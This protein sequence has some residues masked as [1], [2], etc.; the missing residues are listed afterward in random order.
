MWSMDVLDAAFTVI[1][2][3][4][5]VLARMARWLYLAKLWIYRKFSMA[6][7]AKVSSS[8]FD[9]SSS[10]GCIA[11]IVVAH[12]CGFLAVMIK[13]VVDSVQVDGHRVKAIWGRA[14]STS[15]L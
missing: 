4:M 8:V 5:V 15:G 13:G 6:S 11:L 7:W 3:L 9:S 14:Q 1:S 10:S 2:V 12:V